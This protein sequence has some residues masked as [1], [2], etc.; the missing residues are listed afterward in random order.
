MRGGINYVGLFRIEGFLRCRIFFVKIRTFGRFVFGVF[1][2]FERLSVVRF[3]DGF[4]FFE[5][6]VLVLFSC[7]GIS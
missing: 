2:L 1:V 3:C 6:F 7:G 4:V 5:F